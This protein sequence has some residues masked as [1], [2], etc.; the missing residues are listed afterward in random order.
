MFVFPSLLNLTTLLSTQGIKLSDMLSPN[1]RKA[2]TTGIIAK[3]GRRVDEAHQ[4][5]PKIRTS[6]HRR[7]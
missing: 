7:G 5:V 4:P 1:T 2:M 3:Y 6:P